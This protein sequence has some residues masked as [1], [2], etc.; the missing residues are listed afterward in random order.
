MAIRIIQSEE[1]NVFEYQG[2]K[3]YYRRIDMETAKTL[4]KTYTKRGIL[5]SNEFGLAVAE[6]CMLGWEGME[7]HK[8]EALPYDSILIRSLPDD[9][10][11]ELGVA[12]RIS[13]PA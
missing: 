7:D 4:A 9:V 2:A 8:G 10:I 6:W 11:E 3:F 5:D 13:N 1:K 12:M